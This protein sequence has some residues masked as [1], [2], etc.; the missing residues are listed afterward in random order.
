MEVEAKRKLLGKVK[1]EL[2]EAIIIIEGKR[3]ER[4][5]RETGFAP[6]AKTVKCGGKNAEATARQA[7]ENK[8]EKQ[9]IVVLTDFDEE[10]ER[11]ASE[12]TEALNA[13]GTTPNAALRRNFRRLLGVSC[14]EDAPCAL[15][16]LE[17]ALENK[18][19]FEKKEKR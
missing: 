15:T 8:D 4:A 3:D 18:K 1:R 14:V 6:N 17:N 11:R 2:D 13:L 16:R 19:P 12:I 9:Q 7:I 5:L 10:G